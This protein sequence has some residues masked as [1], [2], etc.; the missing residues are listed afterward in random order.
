MAARPRAVLLRCGGGHAGTLWEIAQDEYPAEVASGRAVCWDDGPAIHPSLVGF[1]HIRS[2]EG[3]REFLREL[4]PP[5]AVVDVFVCHGEPDV[6]HKLVP[7][8]ERELSPWTLRFPPAIS[9]LAAVARSATIGRGVFI[10]FFSRIG[11]AV[12]V[13][14]FCRIGGGTS[15]GH[16]TVL[17]DYAQLNGKVSMGGSIRVGSDC[18]L[19]LGTIVRDHISIAAGTRTGM[20]AVLHKDIVEP[21]LTW[22]GM[23]AR[24]LEKK[25]GGKAVKAGEG[26]EDRQQRPAAPEEPRPKR[27]G[28]LAPPPAKL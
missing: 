9:P 24:K 11:N 22:V 19:G 26:A 12:R 1:A 10:G 27:S 3:V 2:A 18:V 7:E 15:V 16:D 4:D 13:G 17:E 8:V 28:W 23:P 14:D 25:G 20:G 6:L 5:A 21:G